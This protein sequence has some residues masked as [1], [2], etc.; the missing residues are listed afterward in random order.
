MTIETEYRGYR[1]TYSE[2]GDEWACYDIA[3]GR[4][5][6][7]LTLSKMKA[8]IDKY[9]L[10]V[11][12]DAS[13]ACLELQSYGR[14]EPIEVTIIEYLGPKIEGGGYSGKP[15]HVASQQVATMGA[16]HGKERQSRRETDLS[17][18][19][20]LGPETDAALAEARRL[21]EI[22]LDA[23]NAYKAA[24]AAIP[25]VTIDQ[26]DELIKVSGLD[27]TGGLK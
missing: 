22:M 6:T 12:E 21:G 17:K 19:V 15:Y 27:P 26:I 20:P 3:S 23:E 8:R 18:C 13:V 5:A 2:N 1:I 4:G 24:V 11:R 7:A 14:T 10:G 9:L 16:R 25:R